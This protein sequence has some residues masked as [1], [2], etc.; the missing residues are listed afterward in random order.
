MLREIAVLMVCSALLMLL[1]EHC[2]AQEPAADE[3]IIYAPDVVGVGR[4]F[5]VVLSVPPDAPQLAVTVPEQVEMFDRTPLPTQDEQRRYY[6]RALAPAEGAE[7][8]FGHPAGEVVVPIVIWSFEELREFREL[9][10]TQLPR[11]WPLG[12]GLP[13]L[14]QGRTVYTDEQVE[15]MRGGSPGRAETWAALSDDDIWAMQPDST[16]P[17]WH[18]VNV[19]YGCPV[20]GT[21]IYLT[22]AY[23]PWI[24]DTSF[25]YRWKIECPV[26]HE[27]YPSNDFGN[28]DMTSGEF[29]DD[30]IGGGYVAPDGKHYGFIAELCQAYCHT[31]LQVAP[32]CARAWIATGDVKYL[33]K[34]L[35]AFCRVAAE[36]AYLAT[37]TQ[38]RHRNS[39]SQ[40]ERLGPGRFDEGPILGATGLT[41]YSIDQPGY[42]WGYAEAYDLIWPDIERDQDIIP[43]LQS[44]GFDVQTHEDVRRFIEENLMAVWMQA[45][46]DGATS[47]N[48][49]YHQRGLVRMAEVLNY[50][51]GDEFMDWLYDG[52]GKMRIFVPNTYFRDGAPYESTGGY[53]GMHV[54]ALGPII[55]SIEHLRELRPEVYPRE[56][57]PDLTQSRRYHNVFDFC[58][59]TVTID[60][61]FPQIGDTGSYP[62]YR[63]LPRT[64]FHSA[65]LRA[66]EHAWRVFRDPKFAWALARHPGWSPSRDFGFTREEIEAAAAQWPDDW[67]DA[68]SL[69]DGYGIAILRGGTGDNKRALWL[70]TGHARGHT[71]DDLMD[72][73]L[74]AFEGTILCHM[75]YPRN[76][77]QWESLWSSHHLAR[78]FNPYQTQT[79]RVEMCA[80]A[81]LAHV[82]EAR[83]QAHTE[84]NDDGTRPEPPAD[85]WQRR[86]LALV[87]VSPTQFYGVDFYRI[88]G[89]DEHWWAFHC[90]E[91][92]YTTEGIELVAQG[93]GTLAGPDVPYGD[94][95]WMRDHGLSLHPSY[96]WRGINFTF[97]HLYNVRKG[98]AEAPWWGDWAIATGE[99]LHLRQHILHARDGASETPVEVNITDGKAASGGSPYE[100][101]WIM[102]HN[103]GEAP[104]RTQVL[105]VIEPYM[106]E[107]VIARATPLGLSG[108]DEAGFAAGACR[109][110]LVSGRIDTIFWSADPTVVREAE[111]GFRFA[112]RFGLYC[113]QDGRPVAVSLIGG[114]LLEKDGLGVR[115]EQAEYRG[116]ITAVDREQVTIRVEPAPPAP[117]ALVGRSIFIVNE[118]KRVGYEVLAARQ[119]GDGAVLSLA[120]DP[121]TGTGRVTG[122][123]DHRVLTDTPFNLHRFGYY[124]GAHIINADGSACYRINEV[125][126]GAFALIDP[127][128]HPEA[129]AERL[130]GEFAEDT[131]FEV[132]D[133]WVGDQV[134]WPMVVSARLTGASTWD[135]STGGSV[136][137]RLPGEGAQR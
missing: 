111:G 32:E 37:M 73:G 71:Q 135:M 136:Q 3:S 67:N 9:K 12:E 63:P 102:L 48:E 75:G 45:A 18:W 42:Q 108:A 25:P 1:A 79:A 109:I 89:G 4:I 88:S 50:E 130:A 44:K 110:E 30:G 117:E 113:E 93:G 104:L 82:T 26:G 31:M 53:N 47:S 87:D 20:H 91:G 129:S 94:E 80:D 64:T 76:W 68:S 22:R 127:V 81:G 58:M 97:P 92:E 85:Y 35:V 122:T 17:R 132:Y 78:Q 124:D 11:R 59:D 115:S 77:G 33:H 15:A 101:K 27:L 131:W 19:T 56:K 60:R 28:G 55:E 21:D 34:S 2:F 24:K 74:D 99:G 54:V 95:T 86:L 107:P 98:R 69:H 121:R 5:M 116:V 128:A 65:D 120:M 126:S 66:F 70:R 105:E 119:V 61:T 118:N 103:Q 23:Y 36:Y 112:G 14:K 29:P 96:G 49:P 90:Q 6:F 72:L 40:V 43:Y 16:I 106:N 83:A 57:Y 100:M 123:A 125:R 13:E 52:A 133:Y 62:Q 84:Y 8:R 10:G 39:Q 51:R 114:T 46:M 134:V 38:H 137:V 7:I 41:V